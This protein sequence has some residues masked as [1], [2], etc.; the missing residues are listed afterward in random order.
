MKYFQAVVRC[1]SFTEAAEEC[2]ISQSAMSQQIQALEHELGVKLLNRENRKISLTP[3][4]EYF[5]R[6][7]MVLLADFERL[8][9][10]TVRIAN[11]D[12]AELRIG[13]LKCYS[14]QEFRLAVAEFSE[15][16][17]DVSVQIINGTHEELYEALRDGGVDLILS[18]QRR[19]FS[20]EYT[21]FILATSECY[22]EIAARNPI[23]SLECVEIDDLKNIPCILVAS[24]EQQETEQR[25]YREIV[26]IQGDFQ[27]A[28]NLEDA[29]LLVIGGNGFMPVEGGKNEPS[30]APALSRLLLTRRGNPIKRTYCAF[31]KADNSGYYIEDFADMLKS[32]FLEGRKE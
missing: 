1:Q 8:C 4:G 10:E 26:G 29:R 16:Y 18:D 20:D 27:F 31:W 28:E 25:Y 30:F 5:Y 15:K 6:K 3:A 9:N 19:A 13:Y 7:S 21:N 32:R 24:P 22:I 11:K 12:R 14:G 2:F 23:A 17:P